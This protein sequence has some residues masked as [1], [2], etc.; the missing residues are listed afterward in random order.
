MFYS[1]LEIDKELAE[2]IT[3]K[4]LDLGLVL[5]FAI[6]QLSLGEV[7]V[8]ERD[9]SFSEYHNR[10]NLS[11]SDFFTLYRK[12]LENEVDP[13]VLLSYAFTE[14]LLDILRL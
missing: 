9:R 1:L 4:H 5:R 14:A 6:L 10:V 12:S 7:S 3:E 2:I 11:R 13:N 8:W